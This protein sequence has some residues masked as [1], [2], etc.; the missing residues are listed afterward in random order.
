MAFTD[1]GS[2]EQRCVDFNPG[3]VRVRMDSR[4][5]ATRVR[6]ENGWVKTEISD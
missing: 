5:L 4:A 1:A 2:G 3:E 6:M